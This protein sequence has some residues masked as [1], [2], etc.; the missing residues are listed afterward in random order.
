MSKVDL[1]VV[2]VRFGTGYNRQYVEKLRN[3]VS[4]HL[5]LPYEFVCLTDD[6]EPINGVKTI[7]Q[8]NGGYKKQWWHKIHMFDKSLDLCDRILYF[9][10]DVVIC[11]SIDKLIQQNGNGLYG[12][13]DFNRKYQPALKKLNSSAMY[14]YKKDFNFLYEKFLK[15]QA[16]M[17]FHGDQD[18]IWHSVNSEIVFWPDEWIQSYKWEIR[19]KEELKDRVGI[20]G[21]KTTIDQE[22]DQQCCVAVF[23]GHPNPA[24]VQDSFVVNNWQ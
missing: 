10:L 2:C 1:S 4:R 16:S 13:R 3:M 8:P 7:V 5:T 24:D 9:D 15:D 12:I 19:S 18:W 11:N 6:S 21:F 23:H 14:W 20:G 17:K 22:V